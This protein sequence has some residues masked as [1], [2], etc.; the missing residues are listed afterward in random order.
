VVHDEDDRHSIIEED[1][2]FLNAY[3]DVC[4]ATTGDEL[5]SSPWVLRFELD[6]HKLADHNIELYQIEYAFNTDADIRSKIQCI[7]S[8]D[9]Y[10]SQLKEGKIQY[11]ETAERETSNGVI[12]SS[13][14]YST[15]NSSDKGFVKS[16]EYDESIE[17]TCTEEEL[18]DGKDCIEN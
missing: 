2:G 13:V 14:E 11:Y 16:D 4:H 6:P 9:N 10:K 5:S 8:D 15:E 17:D 1:Q 3:W 12:E 18:D 7:F